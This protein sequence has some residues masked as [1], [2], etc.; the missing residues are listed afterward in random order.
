MQ[1]PQPVKMG[2]GCFSA[3]LCC[4]VRKLEFVGKGGVRWGYAPQ[5]RTRAVSIRKLNRRNS[6]YASR[7]RKTKARVSDGNASI[8]RP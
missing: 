7:F 8:A 2:C 6:Q 3:C 4:D 5:T 1:N